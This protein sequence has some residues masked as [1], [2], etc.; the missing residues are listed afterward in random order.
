MF[1]GAGSPMSIAS[2]TRTLSLG[3]GITWPCSFY[4]VRLG[5]LLIVSI[6]GGEIVCLGLLFTIYPS[7]NRWSVDYSLTYIRISRHEC[8]SLT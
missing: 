3:A 6:L 5:V 4:S 8:I 1:G 7:I 2:I